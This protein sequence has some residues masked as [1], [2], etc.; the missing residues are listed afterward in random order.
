VIVLHAATRAVAFGVLSLF[1]QEPRAQAYRHA[2]RRI[3][4]YL[5]HN[6]RS[7]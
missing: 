2:W 5:L 6:D 1:R 7:T 4:R 3:W